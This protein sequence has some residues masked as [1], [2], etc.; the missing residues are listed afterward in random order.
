MAIIAAKP[1]AAAAALC[2]GLGALLAAPPCVAQ[3]APESSRASLVRYLDA[4]ADAML[5]ARRGQLAAIATPAQ[6]RARQAKVRAKLVA[7][8]GKPA[9][10]VPLAAKVTGGSRGDGYR[11]ENILYDAQ[12]GRHVA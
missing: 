11:V 2:W 7:L 12:R 10:G 1:W 8:V 3:V 5:A 6:A 9:H 4:Q